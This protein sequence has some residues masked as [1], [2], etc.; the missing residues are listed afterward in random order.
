MEIAPISGIRVMP[1][2]KVPPADSKLSAVFDINALA[3][4]GQDTYKGSGRNSS[5]GQD[6]EDE[7]DLL[8]DEDE[9][10]AGGRRR[11]G[12]ISIFA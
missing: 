11:T 5:G 1:V 7:D 8:V 9:E 4:T 10:T 3:L 2:A 6:N 12:G